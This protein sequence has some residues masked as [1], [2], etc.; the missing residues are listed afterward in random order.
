[1]LRS[2]LFIFLFPFFIWQ[3]IYGQQ[4]F[5]LVPDITNLPESH[6]REYV[7]ASGDTSF[8]TLG[9]ILF[10]RPNDSFPTLSTH[11]V[12]FDYSGN[13]LDHIIL[14]DTTLLRPYFLADDRQPI[15]IDSGNLFF[16]TFISYD[17][18]GLARAYLGKIDLKTKKLARKIIYSQHNPRYFTGSIYLTPTKNKTLFITGLEP[19]A[20]S[21]FIDVFTVEFD[22]DLNILNRYSLIDSYGNDTSF[23]TNHL[24]IDSDF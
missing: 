8:Y 12:E 23:Y 10:T 7:I 1:M 16:S 11:I 9:G 13:A 4:T 3:N 24:Y 20:D 19:S 18:L 21:S 14:K 17:S 5:N 2:L 6:T 22:Y 15:I